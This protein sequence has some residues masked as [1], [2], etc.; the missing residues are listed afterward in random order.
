MILPMAAVLEILAIFLLLGVCVCA[1]A[2]LVFGFPGTVIIVIASL[3]YAWATG[4]TSIH[5]S[6]VVWLAVFAAVAEGI[7]FAAGMAAT[8]GSKPSAKITGLVMVGGIVGGLLG[9]P[10]LFGIGA[11]LGGLIGAFSGGVAGVIWEGGSRE[12]ALR[13]GLT[14]MR[15]R[16]L[17]FVIKATIAVAMVGMV[18]AAL[19]AG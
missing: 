18:V 19:F 4:F 10:F 15:G 7:E 8:A 6:T 14:A 1:L 11:L 16:L 13:T 17:G 5:V 2:S 3:L 9:I 12:H